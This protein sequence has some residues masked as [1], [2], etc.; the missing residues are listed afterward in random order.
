MRTEEE[1]EEGSGSSGREE[2]DEGTAMAQR[3]D[4]YCAFLKNTNVYVFLSSRTQ[5]ILYC[6]CGRPA[7]QCAYCAD[8]HVGIMYVVNGQ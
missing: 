4:Q 1:E 8:Y 7:I 6:M 3:F 2:G 5:P